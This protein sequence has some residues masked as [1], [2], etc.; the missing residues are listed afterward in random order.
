MVEKL[1]ARL[2]ELERLLKDDVMKQ[3]IDYYLE[4][5]KNLKIEG[6]L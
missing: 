4:F 3:M 6:T 5:N 2:M 1:P